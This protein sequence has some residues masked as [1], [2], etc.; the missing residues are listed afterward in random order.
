MKRAR[1]MLISFGMLLAIGCGMKN[2]DYR[3]E[4]TLERMKYDKRLDA[5][6]TPPVAKGKME[7]LGIYLRPP[8]NLQGPTQAF[9]FAAIE[10]GQFDLE[11][12][13]LEQDR[14]SLH[15]LARVD[16]PKA[17]PKKDAPPQPEPPPRGDFNE[18]VVQ[19]I[20]NQTGAEVELSQF[21]P[22]T[23][24]VKARRQANNF[25]AKTIDRGDKEMQV[26]LYGSKTTPYKVALIFEYPKTEKNSISPKIGLTLENFLVGEPARQAFSGGQEDDGEGGEG[27]GEAAPPI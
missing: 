9:Q 12:S 20:K 26:Y 23:K 2:Y 8:Q 3:I 16:R 18:E 7:E 14:Q 10:A 19:L 25:L 27:G 11:N 22:E 15:V 4:Q 5:N 24:Q 13:F 21:K 17:A 1:A 6:L